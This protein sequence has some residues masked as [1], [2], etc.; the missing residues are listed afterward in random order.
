MLENCNWNSN[1]SMWI[2]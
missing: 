1:W 2:N